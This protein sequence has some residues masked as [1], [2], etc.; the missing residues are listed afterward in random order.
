MPPKRRKAAEPGDFPEMKKRVTRSSTGKSAD[1]EAIPITKSSK[2]ITK[3]SPASSKASKLKTSKAAKRQD[4]EPTTKPSSTITTNQT[5]LTISHT[6]LKAPLTCHKYTYDPPSPSTPTPRSTLIFT[7]GAGGTL[8]SPAIT[9]FC[10]GYASLGNVLAFQGS[11]NLA[12]RARGF[13]AC[14]EYLRGEDGGGD[15]EKKKKKTK[16]GGKE[17]GEDIELVLGGRSMG[18]R[19]A[20]LAAAEILSSSASPDPTSFSQKPS[21]VL[22][23]YPLKGPKDIRD[24]ILLALPSHV[25]VL[26]VI[27]DRDAMCPLDMLKEARLK[28]EAETWL[29]VVEGADHGMHVA[30]GKEREREMG[31]VAGRVAAEWVVGKGGWEE[32]ER[33]VRG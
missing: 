29:V 12:A 31:E 14:V 18:A 2:S 5:T 11:M 15:D 3:A 25:S 4:V 26:F 6:S 9:S 16:K 17:I 27:G 21:L 22:V 1:M 23:S 7:H 20:V 24:A 19:A 30:G 13:G 28:M 10:T 8:S 32:R 33:V